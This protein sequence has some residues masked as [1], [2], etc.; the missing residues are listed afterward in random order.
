MRKHHSARIAVILAVTAMLLL[1]AG[2]GE[3]AKTY[4][5]VEMPSLT[6]YA[7]SLEAA[8]EPEAAA[9]VLAT[10][11]AHQAGMT[12]TIHGEKPVAAAA[13]E[14]KQLQSVLNHVGGAAK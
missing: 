7:K 14:L 2:C 9:A 8:G 10:I 11:P 5:P 1:L 12:E 6:E 4:T 13:D 3:P